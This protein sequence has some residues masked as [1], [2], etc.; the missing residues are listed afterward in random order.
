MLTFEC[1]FN[2]LLPMSIDCLIKCS[3]TIEKLI[4][5]KNIEEVTNLGRQ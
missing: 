4:E 5:F 2:S 3:Y 1:Q